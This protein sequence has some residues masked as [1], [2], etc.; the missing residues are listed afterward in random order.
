[1]AGTMTPAVLVL[2]RAV[3]ALRQIAQM[4]A[5]GLETAGQQRALAREALNLIG[6]PASISFFVTDD[7]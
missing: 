4:D 2:L 1:M 6:P 3:G 7:E 5:P